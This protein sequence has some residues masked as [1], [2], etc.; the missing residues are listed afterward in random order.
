[1]GRFDRYLLS[2]LM[3]IFGF[4]SRVL[5]RIYWINRA[6]RLF[7]WLIASGQSASVFLEFTA[8]TLPN[9]IRIVLPIAAF[10]AALYVTNRM[11]ILVVDFFKI[12]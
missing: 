1:M 5:V 9:V 3:M 4:F 7:D 12:I 11:T 2:Q 6:V 8:L 10:A